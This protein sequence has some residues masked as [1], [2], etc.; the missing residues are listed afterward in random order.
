MVLSAAPGGT[1][2][3]DVGTVESSPRRAGGTK[4]CTQKG[5]ELKT[6][7]CPCHQT[8]RM[9]YVGTCRAFILRLGWYS[10]NT[11]LATLHEHILVE[12][13]KKEHLENKDT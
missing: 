1:G 9:K 13:V 8:Q 12:K 10:T 4:D 3:A 5:T 2:P 11:A 6:V 7:T